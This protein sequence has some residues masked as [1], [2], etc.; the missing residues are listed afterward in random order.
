MYFYIIMDEREIASSGSNMGHSVLPRSST[1]NTPVPNQPTPATGTNA[2]LDMVG[3]VGE[4][5]GGVVDNNSESQK[6]KKL[7]SIV[8][9]YFRKE[10]IG[11]KIKAVCLGCKGKL[12]G[13][14]RAGTTHLKNHLK[15]CSKIVNKHDVR[16]LLLQTTISKD[17]TST[18]TIGK[19]KFNNEVARRE[20]ANMII[21]HEY[22]LSIVDHMGFRR[23]SASLNPDFKVVSRNTIKSDILKFFKEEKGDLKVLLSQNEGRV[24]IT[25]D[26]WT[27]SNQKKGYMA[28]TCHFIDNDWELQNRLLR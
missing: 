28:V 12:A 16:Q 14:G 10:T 6:S 3:N 2:A 17:P 25:T 27:A 1:P 4:V 20:L 26:M 18:L 11:G 22:P 15:G 23:Y 5:A 21:L 9:E 13:D 7:T 19:F 24:A 8:W